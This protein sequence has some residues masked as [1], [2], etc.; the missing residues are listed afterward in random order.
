MKANVILLVDAD[1][2]SAEIVALAAL[3]S[4]HHV[5]R[6]D[7]SREAF[8]IL[9][10][11]LDEVD[12]VVVDLD[13]GVGGLALLEAIDASPTAP[14]VIILTSLEEVYRTP[15]GAEHGAAACLGKPFT[16]EKLASVIAQVSA[17]GRRSAAWSSDRWGHPH[18]CE[19][20]FIACT[21]CR[22][23]S[24]ENAWQANAKPNQQNPWP[25]SS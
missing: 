14:P 11:G 9:N 2:D 3:K 19:N 12:V 18:R 23:K 25:T 4:R 8:R 6:A 5:I 16:V 22:R 10:G 1:P 15:I 17:P 24:P 13:P 7:T 20:N 21:G